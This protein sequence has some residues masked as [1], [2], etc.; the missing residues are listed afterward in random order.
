[1]MRALLLSCALAA[2]AACGSDT[3]TSPTDPTTTPTTTV[4]EPTVTEDFIG[5]VAVGGFQFYS[6]TV[7]TNGTVN[8]TMTGVSG[9]MV[10]ATVMLGLG[11]GQPNGTDCTTTTNLNTAAGS[12]PQ[13]T[14]TYA[15]GVY[16]V[17][18]ADIGNLFAP[19]QFN[20]GIAHP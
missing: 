12:T 8:V 2:I 19:A 14:G 11:L 13:I 6:F 9:A 16:C 18:V 10:P 15:P 3:P 17:R 20:I 7:T 5:V 1:M 4:A